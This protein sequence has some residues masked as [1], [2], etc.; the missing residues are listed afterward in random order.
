VSILSGSLNILTRRLA[1]LP[2]ETWKPTFERLQRN[3]DRVVDIQYQVQDIMENKQYR[4][5][6]LLT[7]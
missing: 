1:A 5:R 3:L 7:S 4:T 6:G 2:E